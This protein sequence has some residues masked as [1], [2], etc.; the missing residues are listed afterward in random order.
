MGME[1]ASKAIVTNASS[2]GEAH[3]RPPTREGEPEF[4]LC[5]EMVIAAEPI[6]IVST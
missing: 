1:E 3:K 6:G 5:I 4:S 2:I